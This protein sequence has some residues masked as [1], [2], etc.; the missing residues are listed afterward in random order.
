MSAEKLEF[1]L[2]RIAGRCDTQAAYKI[3]LEALAAHEAEAKAAPAGWKLVPVEPTTEM[4]NAAFDALEAYPLEGNV[5]RHYRA[6]LAAAPANPSPTP[7]PLTDEQ[8]GDRW[9]EL[10]PHS[11]KFTS[12]DW[13]EAGADFAERFHGIGAKP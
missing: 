6:M 5:R 9:A 7:A 11:D 10:L 3:A 13:F 8:K 1:A 4:I 2:R 12:A